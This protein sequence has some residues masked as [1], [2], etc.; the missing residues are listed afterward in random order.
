MLYRCGYIVLTLYVI[1]LIFIMNFSYS[2]IELS[3]PIF[4]STLTIDEKTWNV[5]SRMSMAKDIKA[6]NQSQNANDSKRSRLEGEIIASDFDFIDQIPIIINII[7]MVD[8]IC[9]QVSFISLTNG[10]IR[11]S[12]LI[13]YDSV[14]INSLSDP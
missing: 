4:P 3:Y 11:T 9:L 8:K 13:F 14:K 12:C 5:T 6:I 1:G 7:K 2:D 10:I